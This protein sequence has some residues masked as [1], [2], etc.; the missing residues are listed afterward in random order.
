MWYS[1]TMP[2]TVTRILL[3]SIF[4]RKNDVTLYNNIM[5]KDNTMIKYLINLFK[6]K[7]LNELSEEE[8]LKGL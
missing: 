8:F 4:E 1:L 6:P 7:K 5:E 2:M 3:T